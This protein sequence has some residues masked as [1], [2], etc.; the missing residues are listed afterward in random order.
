MNQ[1]K[2][3]KFILECRKN[4]KMTQEELALKLNVTDRAV[5]HW[6]NG[7]RLPDYGLVKELCEQLEISINEFFAGK[8]IYDKD[9]KN[10]ADE[11]MVNMVD[12]LNQENKKFEKKMVILLIVT[13]LLIMFILFLLPLKSFKDICI[14]IMVI[15][16]AVISNTINIIALALKDK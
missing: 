6:E 12:K 11:N 8:R 5:S 1:E 2:I 3:G 10:V 13:T 7:R 15:V 14:F 9:Y 4:K 16:L